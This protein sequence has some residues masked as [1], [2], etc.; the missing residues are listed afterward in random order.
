MRRAFILLSIM[1][2]LAYAGHGQE[3]FYNLV[4]GWSNN[5][6]FEYDNGY[7]ALGL[8]IVGS[9]FDHRFVFDALDFEGISLNQSYF[10]VDSLE[11]TSFRSNSSSN[12]QELESKLL[13]ASYIGNNSAFRLYGS[14]FEY[15]L[16]DGPIELIATYD[17][18]LFNQLVAVVSKNDST[19]LIGG[20]LSDNEGYRR[21]LIMDTDMEGDVRWTFESACGI[22]CL[23]RIQQVLPLSDGSI[24]VLFYEFDA[25]LP[26]WEETKRSVLL[27]LSAEGEEEWRTY[28]GDWEDYRIDPGGIV[29]VDGEIIVSYTDTDI[30]DEDEGPQGQ[31]VTYIPNTIHLAY[32]DL[33]GV[34]VNEVSLL[35]QI[36]NGISMPGRYKYELSQMQLLD[37]DNLLLTGTTRF[38]AFLLKTAVAGDVFWSREHMYVPFN[39]NANEQDNYIYHALPTSDGGFLCTGE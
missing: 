20:Y 15:T 12:V 39:P 7:G 9:P 11:S 17:F 21:A 25:N 27:K 10:F 5:H 3:R 18:D 28:L 32:F 22:Y 14:L 24:G 13:I 33:E 34:L 19:L 16:P 4:E 1:L 31:Y 6:S 23:S 26:T 30:W 36:P 37:D 35:D 29:E 2:L 38:G 8:E